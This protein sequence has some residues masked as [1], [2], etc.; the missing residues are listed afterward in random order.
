MGDAISTGLALGFTSVEILGFEGERHS[1]GELCGFAF[2]DRDDEDVAALARLLEPC[3]RISVHAPFIS[4]PL[5]AANAGI[6]REVMR[7][8]EGCLRGIA[9]VGG[10]YCTIHLNNVP[11]WTHAAWRRSALSALRRLGDLGQAEGVTIAVETG[12]WTSDA[13]EEDYCSL[14]EQTDHPFVGA[15][16]DTGHVCSYYPAELRGTSEGIAAHNQILNRI[17]ARLGPSLAVFHLHDNRPMDFRDHRVPGGGITD[18]PRFMATV[19][20]ADF[21][22][23]LLLELEEPDCAKALAGGKQVLLDAAGLQQELQNSW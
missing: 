5:L 11:F 1:Q 12:G 7:Q 10:A 22:G 16:I 21:S 23:P 13:G 3:G 4:A 20:E 19:R 8:V 6:R 2:C 18:W 9:R 15:C 17:V 14:I